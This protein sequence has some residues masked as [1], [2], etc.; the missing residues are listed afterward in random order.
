[1]NKKGSKNTII[2]APH[3]TEN[4]Y[5]MIARDTAQDRSLSYEARGLL[6]YLLS[7]PADW[8]II[9]ADIETKHCGR[10]KARNMIKEL[11]A[12]GYMTAPTRVQNEF[13]HWSWT[14]YQLFETPQPTTEK[15]NSD[16]PSSV[17]PNSDNTSSYKEQS[18]QSTDSQ[19]TEEQNSAPAVQDADK[20]ASKRK[21][22]PLFDVI[23]EHLFN[24][25]PGDKEAVDKVG[26]RAGKV[27]SFIKNR[28]CGTTEGFALFLTWY[29]RVHSDLALPKADDKFASAWL[30]F[31]ASAD[32]KALNTPAPVETPPA[33]TGAISVPVYTP[34]LLLSGEY[35]APDWMRSA[36][37][38]A[39]AAGDDPLDAALQAML[40]R[41]EDADEARKVKR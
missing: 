33:A 36:M 29:A 27:Y 28:P 7:K 39:A 14:P 41:K 40:K 4:P 26:G 15:P 18:L 32:A 17:Q 3:D 16:E 37:D 12:A 35:K 6:A 2:R 30:E 20:P 21:A 34:P 9:V 25:K 31:E 8:K 13:G 10:D 1:M 23:A 5:F 19:N 38:A 22:N 24:A 11:V